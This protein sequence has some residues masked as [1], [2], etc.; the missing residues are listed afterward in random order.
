VAERSFAS[1]GMAHLS[2][3]Q[4][5]ASLAIPTSSGPDRGAFASNPGRTS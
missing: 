5:E 2:K 4:S 1:C 3:G